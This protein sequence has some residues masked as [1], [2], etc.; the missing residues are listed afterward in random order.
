MNDFFE[1][2]N[3][4]IEAYREA[5][6]SCLREAELL[7]QLIQSEESQAVINSEEDIASWIDYITQKD[8]DDIS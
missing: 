3:R 4:R 1:A 2:K 5:R 7:G 6:E 8:K